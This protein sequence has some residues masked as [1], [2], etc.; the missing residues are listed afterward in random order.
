MSRL[1]ST[2]NLNFNS[3]EPPA[4]SIRKSATATMTRRRSRPLYVAP[5]KIQTRGG[6]PTLVRNH[7]A[8][9]RAEMESGGRDELTA[10]LYRVITHDPLTGSQV[11]RHMAY[12]DE[13]K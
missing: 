8:L 7:S 6:R 4:N 5:S 1:L 13:S 11:A 2:L 10:A 12:L 9:R 3:S